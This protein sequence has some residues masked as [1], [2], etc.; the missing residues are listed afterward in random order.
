MSHHHGGLSRPPTSGRQVYQCS[1][2]SLPTVSKLFGFKLPGLS[3]LS[4]RKQSLPQE[5][6]DAVVVDSSKRS[7]DSMAMKHF[8]SPA[9]ESCSPS[10]A[11]DTKAL[12]QPSTCSPL[13]NIS[14]PL[15]HSSPKRQ[16]DR[17]YSDML[18]SSS[19]LT[20]AQS[21]ESICSIRRASSVHNIEGFN[22]PPKNVFRD[23]HASEG[24]VENQHL[25]AV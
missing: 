19:M 17:L 2:V 15:D 8:K 22:I 9:K 12:I 23:R 21:K 24:T 14:G 16:W 3:L 10:E 6:P 13:V 25:C 5:D 18:H 1:P 7:D 20:H 4:Y 11:D